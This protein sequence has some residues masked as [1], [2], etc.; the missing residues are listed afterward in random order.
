MGQIRAEKLTLGYSRKK[1]IESIDLNVSKGEFLSIIGPSGVGKSTLLMGL[2]ATT[3]IIDGRL[4]V[5]DTDLGSIRNQQLKALRARIGVIFQGYNLVARLSV[6]DNIASGMLHRKPLL[7]A[8]IRHYSNEQYEEIYEYMKVVGIEQEALSRCDRLSGGQK[9]RV[10]IARAIAQRPEIILADEPISSL[11]PV[12]ARRVMETLKNAN[13]KYGIT[14]V[15]NLHQLD[16]A[17]EF[18]SRVIGLNNGRI[19]YDGP[20][21]QLCPSMISLIYHKEQPESPASDCVCAPFIPAS[22]QAAVCQA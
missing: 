1:V 20:P 10:A 8:L 15:S 12:S 13:E 7:P 14:V 18:C 17:R 21:E 9:Q 11:D 16:Y 2:N 6:L 5:L 4:Q 22:V 3:S 19:V